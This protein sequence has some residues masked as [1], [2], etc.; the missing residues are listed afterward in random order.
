MI[1]FLSRHRAMLAWTVPFALLLGVLAVALCP[2]RDR[3]CGRRC[4]P[5]VLGHVGVPLYYRR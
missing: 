3:R 5:F 2:W 1:E 4:C